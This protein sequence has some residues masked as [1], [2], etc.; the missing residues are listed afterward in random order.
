LDSLLAIKVILEQGVE[1]EALNFM[2][3]FCTCTPKGSSCS[4]A[5]SAA[6]Q[7]G[8][9]VKTVNTSREFLGIVKRPRH[10]YGRNLNP[11]L[12]CR[13]LMFRSARV[14]LEEAGASFIVTGE[15]LGERPMS[16]RREAMRLIEK[17][18]GLEGLIVRPLSAGLLEPSLPEQKGWVDRGR[19]LRIKGRSRRP[20]IELARDY[21]LTDYPCPAGGCLLTDAGF[22]GRMWDLM[23]HRPDFS[24]NDVQLLK[25]G[26]HF[27]LSPGA[28]A[29]VGRDEEDNRVLSAHKGEQDRLLE[30]VGDTGPLTV[31]PGSPTREDLLAAA[32]ITAR[33]SHARTR[34]RVTVRI[35]EKIGV[36]SE[37]VEV[38]P[39]TEDYLSAVRI[40]PYSRSERSE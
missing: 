14:R 11:C 34:E 40:G 21:G 32:A 25:H 3:V 20:Q 31:V 13:I 30:V 17:E 16:Q 36:E 5:R 33:Y 37:V 35:A 1:V 8:I 2:S 27:R 24:L 28:K 38:C 19:L 9:D 22:A 23:K 6:Q 39:A 29:V 4:A 18:S 7:L 15:V 12:D 26:K 10:G